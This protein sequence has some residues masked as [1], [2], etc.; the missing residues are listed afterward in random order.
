MF[1]IQS[2]IVFITSINPPLF[3]IKYKCFVTYTMLLDS[4]NNKSIS[5]MT[6]YVTMQQIFFDQT[7]SEERDVADALDEQSL[8]LGA[9]QA[10]H[11]ALNMKN[12]INK[13]KE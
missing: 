4:L 2:F 3:L 7:K 13:D 12:V 8:S 9:K 11:L 10:M 6:K 5:K 1:S